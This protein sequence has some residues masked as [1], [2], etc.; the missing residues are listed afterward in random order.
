[1]TSKSFSSKAVLSVCLAVFVSLSLLSYGQQLTGTLS[2][3]T[4]DTTGAVVSNAKVTMTNQLNGDVRTTVSNGSGYFSITAVQP[5]TYTVTVEAQGFKQWKQAGIV[6]AQGD[7]RNLTQI[8]L[9]VGA[10]NETVEISAGTLSVPTDNAEISTTVPENMVDAF[11]MGNRDAGE[12]LKIMP[13]MAF[14]NGTSQ[15]SG[16]SDK[17]VGT[18]SGPVGNF[19]A[20]GTQPNGAMAFMLDGANLVDPGNAGTQIANINQD[21]VSEVKVLMSNYSA[22]YAKGP[23]IFQAFSKSGGTHFHGEGYVYARNSALNAID[24]YTHSQIADGST[25]AALGAPAE[26]FYYFGGNLGGPILNKGRQKLFFWAGYEYMRQH[27]AGSIINYNVPTVEQLGGDFSNTTIN[28]VPGN[29]VVSSSGTTLAQQ[30][31]NVWGYAYG[32]MYGPPPGGTSTSVPTADFDPNGVIYAK[33]LPA[34]NVSPNAGNGWNN[35]QY[36]S[37]VPQNR[38]EATGKLD[39]AIG[40]NS[41][42][43]GSYTRQ[44]ETDQ[45]PIGI[46]WTPQWTL[47][48]PSNVQAATTSQEV[49]V[50][51]THVFSPTT[52]N[53]AVF[54]LA[55]YINPNVLT[56]A[57][58]VDRSNLGLTMT[59][60]FGL[61]TKQMPNILGPWG[62][63]FPDIAE[64]NLDGPFNGGGFGAEKKDPSFYDNFT[65]VIGSHTLKF[66]MYWDTSQNIQ[67]SSAFPN[68]P[69]G[70]ANG[71]YAL[72]WGAV[73]TGNTVADFLTGAINQYAQ[74]S[75]DIVNTIQNHQ[76]AIYAQDSYKANRQLTVNYG[77]RFD[78]EG[79]W[80]GPSNGMA[81]WDP[82]TYTNNPAVNNPGITWHSIG[83]SVPLSG[84]KSPLF[85]YEPRVGLAYDVFGNGRTVVRGGFASFRYQVAVNDVTGPTNLASGIYTANVYNLQSCAKTGPGV[86]CGY[87]FINTASTGTAPTA[88]GTVISAFQQNDNRT[89]YT[90]DWNISIAQALP[91]RSV[92]EVS[93]VGNQSRNE[94]IN[95]ANGKLDDLNAVQPGGYFFPDPHNGLYVSPGHLTCNNSNAGLNYVNCGATGPNGVALST[96]YD[97]AFTQN[98]Y[99][100]LTNYQDIY[101]ITHGSYA[102]YNALQ[103]SWKKQSGPIGFLVN[104]SFSKVMGIRDGQSDNGPTNGTTVN[105]FDLRANYGPLAYDHSQILNATYVWNMPKFVH[106]NHILE[107]GINGWVLSGYTTY[108]TGAPLQANGTL[109]FTLPAGLTVP[110]AGAPDLPDNS[111][112]LPNG[113]RSNAV[114]AATWYGTDQ[115]GGG[116]ENFIPQITCDPRNHAKGLYFNPNCFGVPALGQLGTVEWPYLHAPAYFDWDLGLYKSFKITESK[117]LQFRIQATNWL[118][119]PLYQFG[120]AGTG[121]ENINLANNTTMTENNLSECQLLVG[122]SATAPCQVPIQGIATSNTN[123]TTTG[124]PG[125]KTGQRVVTFSAKF[126]F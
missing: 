55:R 105:P 53:E 95:G 20:N 66:G 39:Y 48:Y 82:A 37:S 80:Y 18:N 106:G 65:K 49:M 11:P 75:S 92:F 99:R 6:F 60:L 69:S 113:L 56:N 24:A 32:S 36:V 5:G 57:N 104:Y 111:I 35:Y 43:T 25:T 42:I 16:F 19:S 47:P 85:Y 30:L 119:H 13:G 64:M 90:N 74:P 125:F 109:N 70:G 86:P 34:A 103:A 29:T 121:D 97:T 124:K 63:M 52:T 78:H 114:S 59:G 23:V 89:P 68:P 96:N 81:V 83:S 87:D 10:V 41:K 15:G 44:I 67:S 112:P 110:L 118:N 51:F 73:S 40:D 126:Y 26:S 2:G 76:W 72:N 94:L 58:K 77:L 120:L 115:T 28:G 116:Y 79:Q 33:L 122:A 7:N 88:N 38:W 14:A 27:P 108:Q 61:T 4:T 84:W 22:E 123:A 91:W 93:Y 100:P 12:L 1:M 21:M 8:G 102:N 17:V 31:N 45:H 46:W 3:T 101:L 117:Q 71:S 98:D 54:T 50:N 9:Q 107:T 62:G